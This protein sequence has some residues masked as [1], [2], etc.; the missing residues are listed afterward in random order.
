LSI[1]YEESRL[2]LT[3]ERA[4][5]MVCLEIYRPEEIRI[6]AEENGMQIIA[7]EISEKFRTLMKKV[8]NKGIF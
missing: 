5:F 1:A 8:Y 4:P 7:D 2:F 3:R 6:E